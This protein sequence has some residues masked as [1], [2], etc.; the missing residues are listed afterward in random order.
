MREGGRQELRREEKR[1]RKTPSAR[2][3][4]EAREDCRELQD[5]ARTLRRK[6]KGDERSRCRSA[7]DEL[8]ARQR[9]VVVAL[10]ASS[11]CIPALKAAERPIGH[12]VHFRYLLNN[13]DMSW[14]YIF[15]ESFKYAYGRLDVGI[16]DPLGRG[17]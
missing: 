17:G 4:E 13:N 6:R 14:P 7:L 2:M 1:I 15:S 5:V 3:H 10:N 12:A 11:A 16:L 8:D 9:A